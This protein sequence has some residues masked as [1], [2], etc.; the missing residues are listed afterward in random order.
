MY[1]NLIDDWTRYLQPRKATF[2]VDCCLTPFHRRL[3]IIEKA[4]SAFDTSSPFFEQ[5]AIIGGISILVGVCA[6]RAK[7]S[8]L[9]RGRIYRSVGGVI[10]RRNVVVRGRGDISV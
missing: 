7:S 1:K 10:N 9:L 5:F 6:L 3:A 2:K 8:P 4:C